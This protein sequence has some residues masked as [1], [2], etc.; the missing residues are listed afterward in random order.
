MLHRA[1]IAMKKDKAKAL[2]M[3]QLTQREIG[4]ATSCQA[5]SRTSFHAEGA[6]DRGGAE[7]GSDGL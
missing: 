7:Y 2:E 1:V 3:L 4:T 6:E 5:P